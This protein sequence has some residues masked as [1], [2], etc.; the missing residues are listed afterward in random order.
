MVAVSSGDFARVAGKS[1]H[2]RAKADL[3][4]GADGGIS[5]STDRIDHR[6]VVSTT[7]MS[8]SCYASFV[9]LLR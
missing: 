8:R 6:W 9:L 7:S 5:E 3:A 2:I 4:E 1:L